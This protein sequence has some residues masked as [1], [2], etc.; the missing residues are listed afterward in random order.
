MALGKRKIPS[1]KLRSAAFKRVRA[2][3]QS[4]LAAD[5]VEMIADLID[6]RGEARCTDI[7]LRLGVAN[8]TVVKTISRLQAAGLVS[9]EPYRAIFLTMEGWKQ[10]EDGRR[11]HAVVE[12]FLVTLGVSPDIARHDAEG[13]EHHVSDETLRAMAR[14]IAR[15]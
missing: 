9:Q 10:A 1:A 12:K 6:E 2:D 7:A 11:R 5:Y 4:E 15:S 3:H 14:F 8:A 13:I